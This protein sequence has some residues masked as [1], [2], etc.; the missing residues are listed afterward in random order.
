MQKSKAKKVS[1]QTKSL[2]TG[3]TGFAGSHMAELL[4]NQGHEVF[5]IVRWRSRS[6]NIN[7]LQNKVH[8][9]EADLLD[10]KSLQDVMLSV[11]PDYIFHLA[12]Q[13]F[14]PASWTSP[15]VT[16]ETNA[17]GSCNLFEAIRTAQ[18]NPLIQ[19]AC[20]SEEYGLVLEN[21]VP[22]KETN[23]LRPLSPYAVSKVALDYLGYQYFRSYGLKIVRTRGF[24]HEGPRRGEVFVTSTFAKQIA[25]IEKRLQEPVIWT[26]DLSTQRDFT[27]VR[28]MVRGY[29]LALQKGEPGE[30]YNLASGKAWVIK[31]MLDYLISLSTVKNIEVKQDPKRMRPSDVPILL[32]DNSKF[33]SKTGWK[34]QI[35]FRQTLKD[36]LDYWRA[37]V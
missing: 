36:T 23:P 14:V 1:N 32:G 25:M 31:D 3:I 7:H 22:I 35:D 11:R 33:V 26:G 12:A 29:L 17:V 20:S 5:G 2:I 37:H 21:E 8:L 28:D 9:L 30:V 6:E 16:M 27:D 10:L 24:N 18:I 13:S 19:V 34:P 15:A 4:L